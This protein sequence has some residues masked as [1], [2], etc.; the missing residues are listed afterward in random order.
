MLDV[1]GD[2]LVKSALQEI[3]Q[4]VSN[5]KSDSSSA[6]PTISFAALDNSKPL[7]SITAELS[8]P[9]SVLLTCVFAALP[10]GVI[11]RGVDVS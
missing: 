7:D 9:S 5:A 11:G 2:K 3:L 8:T 10:V 6:A 4:S 1:F